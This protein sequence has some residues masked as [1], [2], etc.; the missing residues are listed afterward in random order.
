M[1]KDLQ[2]NILP[3][4]NS[5]FTFSLYSKVYPA[6]EKNPLVYFTRINEEIYGV[7]ISA[8]EDFKRSNFVHR[9]KSSNIIVRYV[10]NVHDGNLIRNK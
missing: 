7:S 2:I 4:E 10:N 1:E 9:G 8:Y 3:I 6:F 5:K